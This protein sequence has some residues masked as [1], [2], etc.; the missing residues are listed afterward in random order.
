MGFQGGLFLDICEIVCLRVS[1][2]R[3]A[4]WYTPL[5]L[6]KFA[7]LNQRFRCSLIPKSKIWTK[8]QGCLCCFAAGL[9]LCIYQHKLFVLAAGASSCPQGFA[10]DFRL[11]LGFGIVLQQDVAA[12]WRGAGGGERAV[13]LPCDAGVG[14]TGGDVKAAGMGV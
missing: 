12:V 3:V 9:R 13:L 11:R 14:L 7:W 1:T 6:H 2:L 4:L 10:V 8:G 5:A